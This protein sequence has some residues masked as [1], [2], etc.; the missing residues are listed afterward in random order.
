MFERLSQLMPNHSFHQVAATALHTREGETVRYQLAGLFRLEFQVGTV[1]SGERLRLHSFRMLRQTREGGDHKL[2]HTTLNLRLAQT[3]YLGLAP[4]EGSGLRGPRK[5]GGAVAMDY[6]CRLGTPDGLVVEQEHHAT[7]EMSLRRDL[8]QKGYHIFSVQPAGFLSRFS[9]PGGGFRMRKRTKRVKTEAFLIFNQE[10]ASLLHAGLPLLQALELMLER[11]K[12]PDFRP[13]LEDIRN[14]VKAGEDLSAA[15]EAHGDIFPRLYPSTL[16]AGEKSGELESVI[17]RFIRYLQL[18][19][20]ARRKV[21]SALIYPAVLIVL[22]LIMLSVMAL[23]VVPKFT[24]FYDEL[25]AELPLLT[26]IMLG[27]IDTIRGNWILILGGLVGGWLFYRRWSRTQGGMIAIHRFMLELPIVGSIFHRFG[28]AEF[29]RSLST[30]LSGGIP[31]VPASEIAVNGISNAYLRSQ[32]QPTIQKVREGEPFHQALEE[33]EIFTD[34]AV[35]MIKVG[36]ATGALDE[37]LSNVADFL[38]QQVE[39]RTQRLL[40]LVEPVMLVIMGLI[41][42]ILLVSIYLP[43]FSVMTQLQ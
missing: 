2:I 41:I 18:I 7:D 31:L 35:D 4:S 29:S 23:V 11:M 43:L 9:V 6:R 21:T 27:I 24:S 12:D 42:G 39:T 15:F 28:L 13:V 17:R 20:D 5:S 1:A 34:M 3:L 37:M 14:R 19:G 33:S 8:E 25:N 36:E 38:D 26:R 30:L 22:S 16:K 10:M 40:S 32:L